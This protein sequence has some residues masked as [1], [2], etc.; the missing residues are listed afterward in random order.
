[1]NL[2]YPLK[3]VYFINRN[4]GF[5]I[6]NYI[7]GHFGTPV[8]ANV[9]MTDDKGLTWNMVLSSG[10][11]VPASCSFMNDTT[12]FLSTCNG[13]DLSNKMFKNWWIFDLHKNL[14]LNIKN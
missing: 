13:S 3:D 10:G 1:M 7:D 4:K 5:I 9:F 8:E 14:I 2:Y 11:Q 12:G 6:G